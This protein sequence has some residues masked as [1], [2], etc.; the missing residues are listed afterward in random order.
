M[1]NTM[2]VTR[3]PKSTGFPNKFTYSLFNRNRS[4]QIDKVKKTGATYN[5]TVL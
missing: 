5:V 1:P 2:L 3:L 4:A